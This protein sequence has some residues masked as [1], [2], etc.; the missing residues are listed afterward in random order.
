MISATSQAM[1]KEALLILVYTVSL[2]ILA[3]A[4]LALIGFKISVTPM[5]VAGM[6]ILIH[7]FNSKIIYEDDI[8]KED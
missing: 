4:G 2:A 3:L 7:V 5:S 1:I 6:I 8:D